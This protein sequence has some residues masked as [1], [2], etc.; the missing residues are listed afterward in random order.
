VIAEN[1]AAEKKRIP[2]RIRGLPAAAK[3]QIPLAFQQ[4]IEKLFSDPKIRAAPKEPGPLTPIMK[5]RGDFQAGRKNL[6]GALSSA[7]KK[8]MGPR[9]F[10]PGINFFAL[11]GSIR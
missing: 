6:R 7:G 10:N 3:E 9:P 1:P 11:P 5:N 2:G 8:R 4:A